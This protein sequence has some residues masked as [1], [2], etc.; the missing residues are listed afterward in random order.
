M[1]VPT[2]R[3]G[4][5]IRRYTIRI[6]TK[7]MLMT[8]HESDFSTTFY[9]GGH[10]TYCIDVQL[11]KPASRQD[12]TVG[13]FNKIRFDVNCSLEHNFKRGHDTNTLLQFIL[14][15][16]HT[17][18]PHVLRLRFNDASE[19][20]CDDGQVVSL[21]EMS[22]ITRGMTW[23]QKNFGAYL[24][25]DDLEGFTTSEASFQAIKA[26]I[27]WELMDDTMKNIHASPFP[28]D[29]D[30]MHSLYEDSSTWQ[31][32]FGGIRDAIGVAEFC[33]FVA[34]WLSRFM[35]RYFKR[36]LVYLT[37]TLPVKS[38][39]ISYTIGEYQRGGKKFTRKNS[40]VRMR[41]GW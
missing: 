12:I 4:T 16:I 13:N 30:T 17:K 7:S 15:Y 36:R 6:G 26:S 35:T 29:T 5:V 23:Y 14:T 21:A 31:Q 27:P 39:D 8:E 37:Y 28:M 41:H 18:Y 32:F 33:R 3:Q 11:M 24:E 2:P 34:P 9:I 1:R 40:R 22:Y 38:W 25:G 10:D 20:T 19:R